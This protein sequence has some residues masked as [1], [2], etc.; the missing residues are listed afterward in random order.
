MGF[1]IKYPEKEMIAGN[2]KN[3]PFYM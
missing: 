1:Q 2:N 3:V